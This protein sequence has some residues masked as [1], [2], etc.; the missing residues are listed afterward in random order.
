MRDDRFEGRPGPWSLF[1]PV[2]LAVAVG[3]ILAALAGRAIDTVFV[4][5]DAAAPV[6][7]PAAPALSP[8][9]P[10]AAPAEQVAPGPGAQI[11][12]AAA[13]DAGRPAGSAAGRDATPPGLSVAPVEPEGAAGL[14]AAPPDQRS[15]D[16]VGA[17]DATVPALPG[18]IVARRDGAPE[19]CIN[20]TIATR[21]SNGWQQRLEN[22]APV[23][24]TELSTA[25][26]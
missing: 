8:Q 7:A 4:P 9:S 26:P 11:G 12:S 20:G 6:V 19:A 14:H 24:C 23:A 13:P 2:T 5:R 18:A 3:G 25:P 10:P 21:D 1:L 16:A 17:A 22:D 15:T